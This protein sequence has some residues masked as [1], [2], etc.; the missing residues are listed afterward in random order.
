[1]TSQVFLRLCEL[2]LTVT[3]IPDDNDVQVTL[4]VRA[5]NYTDQLADADD[6]SATQTLTV[7]WSGP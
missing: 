5:S 7:Y 4:Y 6:Y 3:H 2:S 1:M